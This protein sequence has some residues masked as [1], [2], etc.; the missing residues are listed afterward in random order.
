MGEEVN[1]MTEFLATMTT[2]LTNVI[3]WM[4]SMFTF[5]MDQ[6]VL[7]AF[8]LIMLVRSV[9]GIVRRWLPGRA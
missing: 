2:F 5:V 6:P 4:T 8:V 9:I 7:L 1:I 3:Q